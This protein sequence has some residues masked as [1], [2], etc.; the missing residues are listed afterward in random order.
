MNIGKGMEGQVDKIIDQAA[1]VAKDKVGSMIGGGKK[2]KAGAGAGAG[3]GVGDMLSGAVGKV[4]T[5]AATKGAADQ[6]MAFGKNL[7]G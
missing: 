7:L 2:E 6:A 4:A 3:G 1:G 5:D